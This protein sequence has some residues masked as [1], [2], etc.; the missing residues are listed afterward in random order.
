MGIVLEVLK[1]G[2]VDPA[3]VLAAGTTRLALAPGDILKLP[4]TDLQTVRRGDD[5]V[6]IVGPDDS[7]RVDQ[8]VVPGFFGAS[9]FGLVQIGADG[10]GN[11]ITPQSDLGRVQATAF[12][13]PNENAP[14]Q[15]EADDPLRA[16][17]RGFGNAR[18]LTELPVSDAAPGLREGDLPPAGQG[19]SAA[20]AEHFSEFNPTEVAEIRRA[21]DDEIPDRGNLGGD[22]LALM[23]EPRFGTDT[24][25]PWI[26]RQHL[27]S[28]AFVLAGA[29]LDGLPVVLT[30]AGTNGA[31]SRR[32]DP[33][34]GAWTVTLH[35][36]DI[37]ALGEGPV[38]AVAR[39]V[40]PTGQAMS[41]P[42]TLDL[43]VDTV[44]PAPPQVTFSAAAADGTITGA[45]VAGAALHAGGTATAGDR[46][47]IDAL[48]HA[49]RLASIETTT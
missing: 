25:S 30:L 6:L 2:A 20:L 33:A 9:S 13:A 18:I 3:T 23:A 17:H 39:Q 49:G 38:R 27:D 22:R 24:G 16:E 44:P 26:S 21:V 45:D 34:G 8:I 43:M 7:G 29:G 10:T 19:T 4:E 35:A 32:I 37:Q 12:D 46:I 1:A 11:V 36:V 47:R 41:H 15:E 28:N 42:A 14:A 40:S 31:L 48:D 5:L